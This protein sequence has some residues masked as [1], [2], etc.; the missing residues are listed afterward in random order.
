MARK[1]LLLIG[2]RRLQSLLPGT[3]VWCWL[4][5]L[6]L[7]GRLR[8]FSMMKAAGCI[9]SEGHPSARAR[10]LWSL[11]SVWGG[12]GRG[13]FTQTWRATGNALEAIARAHSGTLLALD[14][15][16][17]LDAREAGS[18]A[19]LLVN[20]QGKA[21]AT[22]DAEVRARS[23]WRIMLLSSGEIGLGDKIAET[24]KRAKAGQL[25]RLVDVPADAGKG[26]GLFEDTKGHSP[27]EFSKVIKAAAL[28]A[29]ARQAQLSRPYLADD[30]E[31]ALP[32]PPRT[33]LQRSR[34][35][36]LEGIGEAGGQAFRV[37]HQLCPDCGGWRTRHGCSLPSLG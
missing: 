27:A 10:L 31:T 16:G 36:F 25:I 2:S 21:R 22:R 28:R 6:P 4:S 19:Y 5:Q 14:E 17:E 23:E 37:A 29:M 20:G 15:L 34:R 35:S 30:P 8:I 18:T 12:G 9:L 1:A 7:R 11:G 32:A 3:P 13:G 24:G 26:Y 33:A